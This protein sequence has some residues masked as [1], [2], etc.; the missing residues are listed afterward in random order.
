MAGPLLRARDNVGNLASRTDS[1]SITTTYGY[2][3]LNRMT[4]VIYP[5]G[6]PNVTYSYD[7]T[8]VSNAK[9]R[10]DERFERKLSDELQQ[11]RPD[12]KCMGERPDDA[13]ADVF[14]RLYV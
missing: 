7:L 2:D 5:D 13:G 4:N 14:V 12:G 11:L 6:T 9:G 3:A 10:F 8:G 1:R